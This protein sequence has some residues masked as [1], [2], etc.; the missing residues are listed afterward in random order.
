MPLAGKITT[1]TVQTPNSAAQVTVVRHVHRVTMTSTVQLIR[2]A[3]KW[4]S[5]KPDLTNTVLLLACCVYV[6]C[7]PYTVLTDPNYVPNEMLQI[8]VMSGSRAIF[9]AHVTVDLMLESDM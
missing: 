4:A 1:F 6:F 5:S 7:Y 9:M 8:G 3:C 2:V